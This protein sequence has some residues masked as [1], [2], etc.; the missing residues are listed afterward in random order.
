MLVA[1]FFSSK[2]VSYL[3]SKIDIKLISTW[4]PATLSLKA[5]SVTGNFGFNSNQSDKIIITFV[6]CERFRTDHIS[7]K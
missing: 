7:T 3:Q 1:A 6:V 2:N 4:E 5:H